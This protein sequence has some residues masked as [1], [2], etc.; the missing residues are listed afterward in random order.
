[1]GNAVLLG[2]RGYGLESYL[3]TPLDN[4]QNQAQNLYNEALIRTRNIV[5]QVFGIWKRRFPILSVGIRS[6]VPLAQMIIVA[7]AVLHNIAMQHNE[8]DF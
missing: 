8:A 7:S 4:P 2:D 5:E 6:R 3:L 1:M